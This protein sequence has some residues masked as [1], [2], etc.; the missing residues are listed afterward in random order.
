MSFH[1]LDAHTGQQHDADLASL[2][3]VEGLKT[4]LAQSAG[5]SA[6]QQILL[7][8]AGKQVKAQSLQDRVRLQSKG[9][10][11]DLTNVSV[12]RGISV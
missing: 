11:D 2:H 7:T 10:C 8:T 12:G 5:I 4:W 1:V 3:D 9:L 6:A